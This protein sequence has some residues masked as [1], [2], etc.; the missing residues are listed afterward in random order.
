[1]T[2][3]TWKFALRVKISRLFPFLHYEIFDFRN[4]ESYPISR[5]LYW[6]LLMKYLAFVVIYALIFSIVRPIIHK[7]A[8]ALFGWEK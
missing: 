8:Y 4:S 7:A 5:K 6:R 1:M 2:N 3:S